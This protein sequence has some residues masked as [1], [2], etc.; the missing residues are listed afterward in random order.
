L[1]KWE[2]GQKIKEKNLKIFIV[3]FFMMFTMGCGI[4]QFTARTVASYEVPNGTKIHYDSNKNNEG[5][6]AKL[7]LNP[8]GSLNALDLETT[9]TTPESAVAAALQGQLKLYAIF[10]AL[11]PL[12]KAAAAGAGGGM[13][14]PGIPIP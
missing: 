2:A 4:N 13:P 6:K 5:F 7:G 9:A 12:I 11:I 8:D 3:L 14:I 1:A 10:E